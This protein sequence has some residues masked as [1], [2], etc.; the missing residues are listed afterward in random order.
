MGYILQ[1]G[2]YDTPCSER[3]VVV[4]LPVF[5]VSFTHFHISTAAEHCHSLMSLPRVELQRL[6]MFG[7]E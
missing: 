3:C 7:A 1:K 6:E 2:W 4:P 5:D